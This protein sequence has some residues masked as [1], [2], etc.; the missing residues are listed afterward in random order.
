MNFKKL[1]MSPIEPIRFVTPL[2][3]FLED[4]FV[5]SSP[6]SNVQRFPLLAAQDLNAEVSRRDLR[7][8]RLHSGNILRD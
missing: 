1:R 8:F 4:E 3:N 5:L 7:I 2:F 6:I